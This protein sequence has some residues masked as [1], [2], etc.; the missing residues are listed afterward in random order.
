MSF[1]ARYFELWVNKTTCIHSMS[2][3]VGFDARYFE[4]WVNTDSSTI[5]YHKK[6][7]SM[8]VISSF[9]SINDRWHTRDYAWVLRFDARYFELW[10]NI[11]Q[12]NIYGMQEISFDARYFELWVNKNIKRFSFPKKRVS[13]LVIS[14]FESIVNIQRSFGE[15]ED[16]FDARYFELWVN[17]V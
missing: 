2:S 4:L 15:Y 8:L 9:E 1:D 12:T 6:R 3:I 17:Q 16:S 10:V 7:V 13:M 5:L 11:W 14:S